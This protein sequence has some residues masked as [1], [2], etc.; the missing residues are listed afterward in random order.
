LVDGVLA[1]LR[2]HRPLHVS[3]VGGEPLVR[4]RELNELLPKMAAMG[5]YVQVVTSA[6]RQ[7]PAEWASLRRLQLVVSVDGLQ[8]EH[9]AR[10]TPATYERILKHIEGHQVTI[11][12]TINRQQLGR[13]GDLEEFVKFWAANPN[14]RHVW[15]SLYTPQ[16]GEASAERL[17]DQDRQRV[18]AELQALQA[19]HP[20]L[21]A[22]PR[23]IAA[24]EEPPRSPAECVFA[25]T[26]TCVSCDLETL[27][28]PCQFGGNPDCTSCGCIASGAL[29]AVGRYRLFGHLRVGALYDASA[30]IGS[31][32]RRLREAVGGAP[33]QPVMA[34]TAGEGA[35]P[36]QSPPN[37]SPALRT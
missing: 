15:L 23:L 31:G 34:M 17:T 9:D 16:R 35:G 29:S 36:R 32:V 1:L 30:W 7:I 2:K 33:R 14:V 19:R 4:Y 20:K 12:N 10:R 27:I 24:Y 26:T 21:V 37:G 25:R 6:V 3:I 8:P 28:S 13:E 18:A 22:P 11:H 5:L